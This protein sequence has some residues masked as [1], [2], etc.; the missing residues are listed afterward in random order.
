MA[1]EEE[2]AE[3]EDQLSSDTEEA[4]ASTMSPS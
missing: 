1:T 2:L 4:V 3:A